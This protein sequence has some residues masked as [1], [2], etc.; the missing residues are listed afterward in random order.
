MDFSYTGRP[1]YL[2][3]DTTYVFFSIVV[4]GTNCSQ[5]NFEKILGP[6]KGDLVPE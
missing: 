2:L 5:K 6:K 3:P 4:P 1:R